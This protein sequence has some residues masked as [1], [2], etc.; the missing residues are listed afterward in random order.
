MPDEASSSDAPFDIPKG[1]IAIACPVTSNVWQ[2][3]A[4]P[5]DR[6][7]VGDVL[8]IVEAMKMEIAIESDE[9]GTVEEILCM[10][11]APVHAGQALVILRLDAEDA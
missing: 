8:V 1:C 2:I 5:G 4:R 10:Q 3:P 7:E 9:A 6:V 11:G